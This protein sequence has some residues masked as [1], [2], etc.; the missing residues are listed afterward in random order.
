MRS[1]RLSPP[2]SSSRLQTPAAAADRVALVIGNGAYTFAGRLTNPANDATD[3]AKALREIGFDVVDGTDL[4]RRAMEARNREF[5]RKLGDARVPCSSMPDT[6]CRSAA[7][8]T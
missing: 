5:S 3:M 6:E 8:I 1:W 2:A 4:D 7:R